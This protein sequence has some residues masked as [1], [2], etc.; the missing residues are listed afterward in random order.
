[1]KWK[2]AAVTFIKKDWGDPFCLKSFKKFSLEKAKKIASA[3]SEKET[4]LGRIDKA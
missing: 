4:I 2:K 1:M 3:P